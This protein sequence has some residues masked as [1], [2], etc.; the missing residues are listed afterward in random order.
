MK[1]CFLLSLTFIL[2]IPVVAQV[3]PDQRNL[4]FSGIREK[5]IGLAIQ[6]PDLEIADHYIKIAEYNL[7]SAKG[8]WIDNVSLSFNANEFTIN[9]LTGKT[10]TDGQFYPYYPFYNIGISIP[11]GGIFTQPAK[12]KAAREQVAIT[13]AQR[14]GQ[15]REIRAK[16]LSAYEDYLASKELFTLQMQIAE[17]TYNE[18]LQARQKFRNGNISLAEF[19][20][21]S[22]A[23]H[24][25]QKNKIG[26]QHALSL[27]KI[28]LETLIGVPLGSVLNNVSV[29]NAPVD[30]TTSQ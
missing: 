12:V 2:T 18:F 8:W 29:P 17:S 9:R 20:V 23:Y 25:Q 1:K 15:Y 11:I 19:N 4:A 16:V 3:K 6:N 14:N 22:A 5:L 27:N 26:A 7:K 10:P 30:S 24:S 28:K 13:K 21:A